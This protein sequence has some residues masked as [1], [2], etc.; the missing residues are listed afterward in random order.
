MKKSVEKFREEKHEYFNIVVF[1]VVLSTVINIISGALCDIYNIHP[2]VYIVCGSI[3]TF[4]LI[5]FSLLY[6]IHKL[7]LSIEYKGMF[8]IDKQNKNRLIKIPNYKINNDM[9]NYLES[10]F[11]ENKAMKKIWEEGNLQKINFCQS[12]KNGTIYAKCDESINLFLEL[13]EYSLLE[14]FSIFISDYFNLLH[15]HSKVELWSKESV[16][17]ILLTNRFLKLFSEDMNNRSAFFEDTEDSNNSTIECE[18]TVVTSYKNGALYRRFDLY[19]P[20]GTTIHKNN[21]NSITIDTKLFTLTIKYLY[22][23]FS[24]VV[25]N[26]FIKY[27]IGREGKMSYHPYQFNI[28]IN[29]KYKLVSIFKIY[30]WKYYNWLDEYIISLKH[31][32]DKETFLNDICWNNNKTFIKVLEKMNSSK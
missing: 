8:I 2:L 11:I 23:G 18:G 21:N 20:K 27:Y 29:V 3:I 30:D 31:Y 19:L 6:R 28:N 26:E 13:V 32:C 22:G 5:I 1:S 15:L 16:P 25:D 24:T 14:N 7:N 17:D 4:F 10:S 9:V 12:D